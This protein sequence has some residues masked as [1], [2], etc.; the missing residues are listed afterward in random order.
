M[1]GFA[2]SGLHTDYQANARWLSGLPA[3][4]DT[5]DVLIVAGD[6]SDSLLLLAR[7]LEALAQ[8]FRQVLHVP[9]NH[10]LWVIRDR[11]DRTSL[12][13]FHR[14]WT[15]CPAP[16]RRMPDAVSVMGTARLE[17][18]TRGLN[19]ITHVYGHSH[20][21]RRVTLDGIAYVN[22]ALG[23]PQETRLT[24]RHLLCIHQA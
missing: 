11:G 17:H 13:K 15:C 21:N 12:D 24:A 8:R 5:G 16:R 1:K 9:G 2:L 22:N 10:D 14:A 4:D 6:V 23:Y 19:L 20:L 7:S 18:Q 3:A